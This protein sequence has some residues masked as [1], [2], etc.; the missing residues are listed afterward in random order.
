ME[1]GSTGDD[2]IISAIHRVTFL[3]SGLSYFQ[4]S[5]C[6]FTSFNVSWH[7]SENFLRFITCS[8]FLS[9]LLLCC[10]TSSSSNFSRCTR[11]KWLIK[12][13]MLK[14]LPSFPPQHT[15]SSQELHIAIF[16]SS[17]VDDKVVPN[18]TSFSRHHSRSLRE[19]TKKTYFIYLYE[20]INFIKVSIN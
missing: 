12:L 6:S 17:G 11:H 18:G 4:G 8:S 5:F 7:V 16:A 2:A 15:V 1:L 3:C 19:L 20:R 10:F 9:A 14:F 13:V